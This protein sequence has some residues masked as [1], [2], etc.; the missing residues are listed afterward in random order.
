MTIYT[1]VMVLLIG[2]FV[3]IIRKNFMKKNKT[4]TTMQ[5]QREVEMKYCASCGKPMKAD[6]TFC[7]ACGTKVTS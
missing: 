6:E 3:W 5:N 4:D 1:L 2:Y 7:S